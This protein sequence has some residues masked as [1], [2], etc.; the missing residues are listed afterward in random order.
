MEPHGIMTMMYGGR[1]KDLS[2]QSMGIFPQSLNKMVSHGLILTNMRSRCYLNILIHPVII[3]ESV[4]AAVQ[5]KFDSFPKILLQQIDYGNFS[6]IFEVLIRIDGCMYAVKQSI[7]QFR[8][9]MD[10]SRKIDD[11]LAK[12]NVPEIEAFKAVVDDYC[13]QTGQALNYA[14]SKLEVGRAVG[15]RTVRGIEKTLNM[16]NDKSIG[17]YLMVQ[18]SFVK[19]A[20]KAMKDVCRVMENKLSG[21]KGRSLSMAARVVLVKHVLTAIPTY[22]AAVINFRQ[23]LVEKIERICRNFIWRGNKETKGLYL[24]GWEALKMPQELGGFG[25]TDIMDRNSAMML[26]LVDKIS[27]GQESCWTGIV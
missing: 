9:D 16:R 8:Q 4:I 5:Y 10:R 12:G 2:T 27:T 18:I 26:K 11:Q 19:P 7:R 14:K 23:A 15:T 1:K 6:N 22:W 21:W 24:V 25:I 17:R 13:S 20:E 3:I